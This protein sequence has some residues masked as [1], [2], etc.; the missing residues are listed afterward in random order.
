ML[1]S[2]ASNLVFLFVCVL[3]V[4]FLV[5]ELK[6]LENKNTKE[7]G[8]KKSLG[9]RLE[10]VIRQIQIGCQTVCKL[11]QKVS[12]FFREC[13]NLKIKSHIFT[14]YSISL[15]GNVITLLLRVSEALWGQRFFSFV[16]IF[17]KT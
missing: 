15:A 5:F 16:F 2:K 7:M 3:W 10:T 17:I 13:S 8:H 9:D 1:D 12:R 6:L 4:C 11:Y 14:G